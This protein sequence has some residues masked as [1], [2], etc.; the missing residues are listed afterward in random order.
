MGH[1]QI[2]AKTFD[3]YLD[4]RKQLFTVGAHRYQRVVVVL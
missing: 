4:S 2:S 3:S 1:R